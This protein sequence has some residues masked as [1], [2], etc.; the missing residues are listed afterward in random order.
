MEAQFAPLATFS[1]HSTD[2]PLLA[3]VCARPWF[4]RGGGRG[5]Q[6]AAPRPDSSAGPAGTRGSHQSGSAPPPQPPWTATSPSEE[7]RCNIHTVTRHYHHYTITTVLSP[8]HH[9]YC[10]IT[11]TPSPLH[12]HHYTITT[13]PSPL[14]HHHY[15]IPLH[16]HHYTITN[17][18]SPLHQHRI[19]PRSL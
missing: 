7:T 5:L 12:H 15:T 8:L 11:T 14:H 6:P 13:T 10:T 2:A 1:T 4:V 19:L 3:C 17:T 16:H 18:P 9:H